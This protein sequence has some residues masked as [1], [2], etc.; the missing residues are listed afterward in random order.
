MKIIILLLLF[1]FVLSLQLYSN[2]NFDKIQEEFGLSRK[3]AIVYKEIYIL[4]YPNSPQ[5]V[6]FLFQLN[7]SKIANSL[8]NKLISESSN[9]AIYAQALLSLEGIYLHLNKEKSLNTIK[10]LCSTYIEPC[11]FLGSHFRK[12]NEHKSAIQYLEKAIDSNEI[13]I[14]SGLRLFYS[15]KNSTFYNIE[16]ANH[17]A[18][19]MTYA[20]HNKTRTTYHLTKYIE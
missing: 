20:I 3:E 18:S 11:V 13:T 8:L 14:F 15:D 17:Y 7:K 1:T 12:N 4:K 9:E 6:L 2:V 5:S 16:K 10:E 19:E